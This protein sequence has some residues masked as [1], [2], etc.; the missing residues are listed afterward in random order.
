MEPKTLSKLCRNDEDGGNGSP[1]DEPPPLV[2]ANE[3]N[4]SVIKT[5]GVILSIGA[6][7]EGS[8]GGRGSRGG[9]GGGRVPLNPPKPNRS[10]KDSVFS[11]T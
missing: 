6:P 3:R 2:N 9:G 8:I 7:P 5:C 10:P 11:K 1:S 4:E